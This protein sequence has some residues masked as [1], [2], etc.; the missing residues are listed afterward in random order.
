M[1]RAPYHGGAARRRGKSERGSAVTLSPVKARGVWKA[2]TEAVVAAC[3]EPT[4][5]P[6]LR[7]VDPLRAV[8]KGSFPLPAGDARRAWADDF[9][10]QVERWRATPSVATRTLF[11]PPLATL[12][13]AVEGLCFQ[14]GAEEAARYRAATGQ[15][16]D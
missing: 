6:A 4:A 5:D 14:L 8:P 16:D 1:S 13:R 12:G 11:A 15:K 9:L 10:E 3:A 2:L 7:L